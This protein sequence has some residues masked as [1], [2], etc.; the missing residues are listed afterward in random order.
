MYAIIDI[1][2]TGGKYNE[3][4]ITEIAI[5]KFDGHDVV[6]KFCSLINPERKIQA[7][8]VKLTGINQEMLRFAP[9]FHEV[10]K[11]IVEIT[12]DCIIVAHNAK[13]DYRILRTEFSRLGF[14]YQRQSLCTVELSKKLIPDMPSYSLGKLTKS[15]GI[16]L[17]K[18]HRAEGDAQATVKLLKLLLSK[19]KDKSVL[20]RYVRLKPK[21]QVDSKLLNFLDTLPQETGVYFFYDNNKNPLYVGKSKNIRKRI[22]QHFT[23]DNPKSK[24]IQ[25]LT[26]D[27]Q[28]EITGNELVALLK[29]NEFIKTLQPEFNN[30]LTKTEFTHGVYVNKD[31]DDYLNFKVKPVNDKLKALTTF[32]NLKSAKSFLEQIVNTYELCLNKTSLGNHQKSCFNYG[33]KACRGACLA[34]E[35][36]ENYNLRAKECIN[37]YSFEGKSFLI[38]TKG[39]E[40]GEKSLVY[41][42][43]GDIAGFAYFDLNLQIKNREILERIIT[44]IEHQRDA[45]HI[46]QSYMRKHSNH[47]KIINL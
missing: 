47:I 4:G 26:E 13:F 23:K 41:I 21:K 7:F 22:N 46:V 38:I 2:S 27:V 33:I 18:R 34:K 10:A 12:E 25:R 28:F 40:P 8:V 24:S 30:A 31:N 39:R 11:R 19:D 37:R 17:A 14:D 9:K 15:L 3:E 32:S 20:N 35:K 1:E 43:K 42:K 16:P 29:E 6:D 36:A 44:P 45:K 5:Y